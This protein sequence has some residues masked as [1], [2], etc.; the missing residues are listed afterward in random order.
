MDGTSKIVEAVSEN[1][2]NSERKLENAQAAIAD[3]ST[4]WQRRS[5]AGWTDAWLAIAL[6]SQSFHLK[7][8]IYLWY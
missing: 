1:V 7:Q 3:V 6:I 8:L 2:D 4:E 5:V